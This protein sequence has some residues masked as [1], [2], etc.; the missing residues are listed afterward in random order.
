MQKILNY[1]AGSF[2]RDTLLSKL[3]SGELR[4]PQAEQIIKDEL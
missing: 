2:S 3:I 4:V 1:R